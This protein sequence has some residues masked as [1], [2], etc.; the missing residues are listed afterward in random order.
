MRVPPASLSPVLHTAY[1]ALLSPRSYT[2][3]KPFV[4]RLDDS[5]NESQ[6]VYELFIPPSK[7]VVNLS[8][9]NDSR[10]DSLRLG[11]DVAGKPKHDGKRQVLQDG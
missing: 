1:Q 11:F 3:N 9:T 6:R 7:M 5:S 8:R 4:R 2:S 10:S